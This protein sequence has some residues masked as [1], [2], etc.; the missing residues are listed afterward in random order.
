MGIAGRFAT[1]TCV[2]ILAGCSGTAPSSPSPPASTASALPSAPSNAPGA[3]VA[4]TDSPTVAPTTR[5]TLAPDPLTITGRITDSAAKPVSTSVQALRK[6]LTG[7]TSYLADTDGDGR[8]RLRV[9]DKATYCLTTSGPAGVVGISPSGWTI[10]P[11]ANCVEVGAVVY[12]IDVEL[13]AGTKVSG[14]VVRSGKP[15]VGDIEARPD[16][17]G[18]GAPNYAGTDSSG[19]FSMHLLPGT[20]TLVVEESSGQLVAHVRVGTQ[21]ITGISFRPPGQ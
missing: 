16:T 1:V 5:P 11:G 14:R 17:D 12:V 10:K 2:L 4:P 9:G 8:Y 21:P 13:P 7:N 18:K 20:Y 6:S 19:R 15:V 3:S